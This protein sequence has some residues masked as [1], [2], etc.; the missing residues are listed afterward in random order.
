M[1]R[2]V[3]V[4]AGI[5]AASAFTAPAPVS[6]RAGLTSVKMA[7]QAPPPAK[8]ALPKAKL[9]AVEVNKKQW[10]IGAEGVAEG[11]AVAAPAPKAAAPKAA[12]KKGAAAAPSSVGFSG[13]PSDFRRPVINNPSGFPAASEEQTFLGM[14]G[15]RAPGHREMFGGKHAAV[16]LAMAALLFQPIAES[17]M[18]SMDAG[19]KLNKGSF[20]NLEVPAMGER[21]TVPTLEAFFPFSKNGVDASGT[22]FGPGSQI[23]VSSPLKGCGAMYG[24]CHTFLDEISDSLKGNAGELPRSEGKPMSAFPWAYEKAAWKK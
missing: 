13:V 23:V 7:T 14:A 24:T 19:G 21:K 9:E 16:S 15:P 10:G 8:L 3:L 5:A 18:Y 17:G 11:G 22:L 2:T 1:R 12:A 6:S 4:L 20:N